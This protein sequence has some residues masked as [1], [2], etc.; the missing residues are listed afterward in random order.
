MRVKY[1]DDEITIEIDCC[2]LSGREAIDRT[3]LKRFKN[4]I[5][6]LKH[7]SFGKVIAL[8]IKAK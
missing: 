1:K 4:A 2:R 8:S 6:E 5:V 7:D 3:Y